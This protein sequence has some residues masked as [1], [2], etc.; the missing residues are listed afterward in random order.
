MPPAR[1]RKSERGDGVPT[2]SSKRGRESP[3]DLEFFSYLQD[4]PQT[5]TRPGHGS[6]K[7]R[8]IPNFAEK[9]ERAQEEEGDSDQETPTKRPRR[10]ERAE[11]PAYS[12]ST[13]SDDEEV[14]VSKRE[15]ENLLYILTRE[16]ALRLTEA[17]KVPD[18]F[19]MGGEEKNLYLSLALRGCKPV[20]AEHWQKDFTT[21]PKSLFAREENESLVGARSP[22]IK[23]AGRSDFSAIRAFKDLLNVGATVRDC[24]HLL[25][26]PQMGT[27]KAIDRY[28]RWAIADGGL[29][30]SPETIRVYATQVQGPGQTA[31]VCLTQ[32]TAKLEN[33]AKRFHKTLSKSSDPWWPTLVG[34]A[35]CGPVMTLVSLDTDVGSSAWTGGKRTP[36]KIIGHFDLAERDEDVWNVLAIAIAIIHIRDTMARLASVNAGPH[37]PQFLGA[38][39]HYDSEDA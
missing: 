23:A 28:L 31:L 39:E 13:S 24:R 11:S 30:S 35:L 2:R 12:P 15:T 36:V 26:E 19:D 10:N 37:V 1:K 7:H 29:R 20:M 21:L 18:M 14:N 8:D 22:L 33:T 9:R 27:R 4:P 38:Y 32:L 16:K 34:F 17:F 5:P 3:P 6:K 25:K